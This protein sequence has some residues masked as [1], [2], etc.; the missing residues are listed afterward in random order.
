MSGTCG[1]TPMHRGPALHTQRT[2]A[3]KGDPSALNVAEVERL[4]TALE[5]EARCVFPPGACARV[6]GRSTSYSDSRAASCAAASPGPSNGRIDRI[7]GGAPP[8]PAMTTAPWNA[9]T[10]ACPAATTAALP[11]ALPARKSAS[12]R[13]ENRPRCTCSLMRAGS[14]PLPSSSTN[15]ESPSPCSTAAM[16]ATTVATHAPRR[17]H[18]DERYA[19]AGG[20]R[21]C[22]CCGGDASGRWAAAA[23]AADEEQ[24]A[25]S[26]V[27]A[28]GCHKR[29]AAPGEHASH[30]I[31]GGR[32]SGGGAGTGSA[33][34]ASSA[35]MVP[36]TI[37]S[38]SGSC[39]SEDSG[40]WRAG[41][42]AGSCVPGTAS[43]SG[44]AAA[45][46]CR[47]CASPQGHCC[48][49]CP[50]RRCCRWPCLLI[51]RLGAPCTLGRTRCCPR[52][53]P[54]AA[55]AAEHPAATA[56]ARGA[57]AAGAE[58][59]STVS[60]CQHA[61]CL[62]PTRIQPSFRAAS[63]SVGGFQSDA[64]K[65]RRPSHDAG[66]AAA[67]AAAAEVAAAACQRDAA[68]GST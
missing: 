13:P 40:A 48:G 65:A 29:D 55:V 9:L 61:A 14:R 5:L 52:S 68:P 21:C 23:V 15:S 20:A 30:C 7:S 18:S 67:T 54:P 56:T 47:V 31:A 19:A 43:R 59:F 62:P 6:R 33:A 64:T 28:A 42:V 27:E 22:C 60:V 32:G 46:L 45:G 39:K 3:F 49:C 10:A 26:T 37:S 16:T 2:S 41:C 25:A 53:D 63:G 44:D 38:C 58:P 8:S 11:G 4:R 50:S 57:F 1:G 17:P 36:S 51:A 34:V 24:P 12:V 35:R 66:A